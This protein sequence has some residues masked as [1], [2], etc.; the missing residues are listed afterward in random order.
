MV[1]PANSDATAA[2]LAAVQC[3]PRAKSAGVSW[4]SAG[5]VAWVISDDQMLEELAVSASARVPAYSS[6][7]LSGG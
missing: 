7:R 6:G 2:I 3:L 5:H 4:A 1:V